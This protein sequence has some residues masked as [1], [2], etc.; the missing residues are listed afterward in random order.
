MLGRL[1]PTNISDRFQGYYGN[2]EATSSKIVRDVFHKGDAWFRTGD[3]MRWEGAAEGRLYFSDRI[4]DTFRWKSENVSTAE[5]SQ[6]VG[7]HPAVQEAN[8][9]G[10]QLP[11]HDGR[12]GCAAVALAEPVSVELLAGLARHAMGELPRYA[13][14]VFVRVQSGVGLQTT[15]TNKQQKHVLRDQGADPSKTEGDQMFWLKDGT[16]APWGVKEWRL[17]EAGEI[18]L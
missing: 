4:G 13:V 10:V 17:L 12:A 16:Y 9:Y 14:P 3:M 15:G 2:A 7:L 1:D 11:H 18:R 6:V 5:V 8:V